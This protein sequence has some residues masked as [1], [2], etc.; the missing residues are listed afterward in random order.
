M[1]VCSLHND[2]QVAQFADIA[3]ILDP[4]EANGWK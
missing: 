1:P 3:L 2:E 4:T